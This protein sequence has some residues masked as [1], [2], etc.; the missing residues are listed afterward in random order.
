VAAAA[1]AD[2]FKPILL[3]F[4]SQQM[5]QPRLPP[6]AAAAQAAACKLNH[7]HLL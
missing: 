5:Q 7:L 6:A 4:D 2:N 3:H 1:T